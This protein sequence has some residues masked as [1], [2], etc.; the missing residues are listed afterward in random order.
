MSKL[1]VTGDEKT[2]TKVSRVLRGFKTIKV[3]SE[4]DENSTSSSE[5]SDNVGKKNKKKRNQE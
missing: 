5:D 4:V 2:L 3:E 1:I